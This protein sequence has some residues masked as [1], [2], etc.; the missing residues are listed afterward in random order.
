MMIWGLATV[1]GILAFVFLWLTIMARRAEA[2]RIWRKVSEQNE[3]VYEK[4]ARSAHFD[5][6]DAARD[7]LRDRKRK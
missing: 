3:N 7:F 6:P 2:D 1:V 4:A 5:T